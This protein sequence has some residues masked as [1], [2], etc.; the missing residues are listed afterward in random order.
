MAQLRE[1]SVYDVDSVI[2]YSRDSVDGVRALLMVIKKEFVSMSFGTFKVVKDML[3]LFAKGQG[4]SIAGEQIERVTQELE[5]HVDIKGEHA[6]EHLRSYV[7]SCVK[8]LSTFAATLALTEMSSPDERSQCVVALKW[9]LTNWPL[10]EHKESAASGLDSNDVKDAIANEAD[11][12]EKTLEGSMQT[13][14]TTVKKH[15]KA[16][17]KLLAG[18]DVEEEAEFRAKMIGSA[19][20]LATAVQKLKV[21]SDQVERAYKNQGLSFAAEQG[22]LS[23]EVSQAGSK[24]MYH[25]TVYAGLTLYRDAQTWAQVPAATKSS[26]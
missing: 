15:I 21:V 17:T 26:C 16:C 20:K 5:N 4:Q 23:R 7:D 18:L 19:S 12:I 25:I 10:A 8:I 6:E 13:S 22:E 14:L 11:R 3:E 24:S 9:L 1:W 2:E